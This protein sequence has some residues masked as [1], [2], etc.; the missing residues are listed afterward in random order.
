MTVDRTSG[1]R[2]SGGAGTALLVVGA[3]VVVL[4]LTFVLGVLVGRGWQRPPVMAATSEDRAERKAAPARRSGLVETV[5]QKP[6]DVQGRLT[7]YQTLTAPATPAAPAARPRDERPAPAGPVAAAPA[8]A[9]APAAPAPALPP[10]GTAPAAASARTESGWSVQVGA[11][12][13]RAQAD[14]IQRQLSEAGFST[15]VS[16]AESDPGQTRFRVR[17]GTFRSRAEA[18]RAAERLRAERGLPT[19]VANN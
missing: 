2:S 11:F 14:G 12:R 4:G 19:F 7:F 6:G 15:F 18:D 5:V 9:P 10:G 8:A 1:R 3:A 13:T 17:V 16:G